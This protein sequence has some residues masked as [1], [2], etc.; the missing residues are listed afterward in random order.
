MTEKVYRCVSL[1]PPGKVA[2]YGQVAK[3]CGMKS[4][5]AIGNILHK[6]PDPSSI[7]CHRVVNSLGRVSAQYAFGGAESQ[8][9]K[10][11][12]EGVIFAGD[13]VDLD[14]SLWYQKL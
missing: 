13:R 3:L 8:T 5:R 7:P 2:T 14:S 12:T 4:A 9:K 6:N 1:I 11:L 10:L